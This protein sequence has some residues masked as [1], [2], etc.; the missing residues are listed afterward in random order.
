LGSA[1]ERI[2]KYSHFCRHFRV[3]MQIYVPLLLE[4]L[5]LGQ[6]IFNAQF[7]LVGGSVICLLDRLM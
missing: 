4:L 6:L 1:V 3:N 2:D 7:I 5:P